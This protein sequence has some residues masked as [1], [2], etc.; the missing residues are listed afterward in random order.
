MK[1]IEPGTLTQLIVHLG[2]SDEEMKAITPSYMERFLDYQLVTSK[3]ALKIV[4]ELGFTLIGWRDL[5]RI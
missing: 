3:E 2:L 1:S 5:R 4:E